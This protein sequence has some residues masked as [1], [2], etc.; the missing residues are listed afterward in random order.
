[1]EDLSK[2][3]FIYTFNKTVKTRISTSTNTALFTVELSVKYE[4]N[5]QTVIFLSSS[6][7]A[8]VEAPLVIFYW[9]L[10]VALVED[11]TRHGESHMMTRWW[12]DGSCLLDWRAVGSGWDCLHC[13]HCPFVGKAQFMPWI[14]PWISLF[15][16]TPCGVWSV[17]YKTKVILME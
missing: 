17:W 10:G 11:E 1:M 14:M 15:T 12:H 6:I 3:N 5:L 9:H 4:K 7:I 13:C 16:L 8:G 2:S